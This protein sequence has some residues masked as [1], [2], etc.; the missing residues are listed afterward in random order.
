MMA[1]YDQE[2]ATR[3]QNDERLRLETLTLKGRIHS[4]SRGSW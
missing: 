4:P 2:R 3:F 1:L